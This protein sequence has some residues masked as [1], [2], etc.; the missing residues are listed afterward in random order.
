VSPTATDKAL[1]ARG[2]R[3]RLILTTDEYTKLNPGEHGTIVFVD[4]VG[5]RHVRWDSGS[6][7]GLIAGVDA[8][9][10]IARG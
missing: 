7:L 4:S 8:W 2:D 6:S 1:G 3:V 5:T 10:V 9:E